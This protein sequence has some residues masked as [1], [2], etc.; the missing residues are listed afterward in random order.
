MTQ[1][2][3]KAWE[4]LHLEHKDTIIKTFRNV[5]LSLNPNSSEDNELSIRDLP[6]IIVGD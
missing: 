4:R 1:W 6:N 5:G 2:V 3:G